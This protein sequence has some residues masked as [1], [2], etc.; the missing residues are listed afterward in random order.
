VTILSACY[1]DDQNTFISDPL[2]PRVPQYS[3]E[4]ANTAGAYI[5]DEPW[6]IRKNT[7]YSGFSPSGYTSGTLSFLT[8][9]D[10]SG[11]FI[12]FQGGDIYR[13]EGLSDQNCSV[14]FFLGNILLSDLPD[15]LQLEGMRI[16]L[17][18]IENFGQVEFSNDFHEIGGGLNG[19]GLLFIRN[20][21][22]M[23][24]H[25]E[26]SGT[27]GFTVNQGEGEINVFSGRFDYEVFD[28]QF[29]V[30]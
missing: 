15:L 16:N 7:I 20:I 8:A 5:D 30:F 21:N 29:G 12:A 1:V 24:S 23:G 3:E 17:D 27:F 18:G 4:G 9:S 2:D 19:T 6:V 22:R 26:V 11:T 25:Y 13:G 14:G 28:D 10:S